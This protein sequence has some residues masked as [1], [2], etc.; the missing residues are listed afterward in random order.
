MKRKDELV[1]LYTPEGETLS[2]AP[3]D[4]PV[5]NVY[6]RPHLRRDS[7]LCLN[8]KWD[9]ATTRPGEAPHY[10]EQ[11]LVPFPP[12]S[13][14]SGIGRSI[15]QA[16]RLCYRRFFPRPDTL[17]ERERL[18][19]HIGAVDQIA[20]VFCNGVCVARHCGGYGEITVELTEHLQEE[21][22][23]EIFALDQL[24]RAILPYGKQ[25]E[26]RGGMWYTPISGIWQSV[27]M[28][29]VPCRYIRELRTEVD[30]R[31]ATLFVETSD[32][33]PAEGTVTLHH[34]EGNLV[35]SLQNGKARI[36]PPTPIL[37]SPEQPHLYEI[38]V[39]LGEDQVRSYF[40]LRTLSIESVGGIPRLCLNRKPYFFHGLLDQ[41]YFPDGIFLPASPDGYTRDIL[42]AKRLGFNMLRKHIKIEPEYFYYECDRLGIAVVQDMVNNASY[43]FFRDTALPTIGMKHLDDRKLH[44]KPDMRSAFLNGM[45]ETVRR[46]S[47]HPSVCA[48]TIFNEGWGQFD[49][50]TAYQRLKELDSTRFIDSVS[51]WFTPKNSADLHSDV[52]SHHVYFKPVKLKRGERPLVLSEFGGYSYKLPDHSFNL[53]NNYGY[54]TFSDPTAFADALERLYLEEILPAVREGLCAA[55]YTQLTDVEDETNG[56]L[57]YDRRIEKVDAHR[58]SAIAQALMRACNEE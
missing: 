25:R 55:V 34:S 58:M 51:G 14:L 27:W 15:P 11:I 53:T 46:L 8:G 2:Q 52:D 22:C 39:T 26:K 10:T 16:D 17:S 19:L 33:T 36:E 49:H 37:W 43:S 18:L 32:S 5:W 42:A 24:D 40:A 30:E 38:T 31:G 1:Q 47:F 56:L 48:W 41:G 3:S 20:E 29:I 28:E 23:L 9:F 13:A 44:K 12:Q 57:S 6:P 54:K 45:E 4:T 50:A 21:N 35:F 7:F